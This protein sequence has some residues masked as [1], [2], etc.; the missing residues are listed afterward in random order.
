MYKCYR[1]QRQ[2]GEVEQWYNQEFS[3][4][5]QYMFRLSGEQLNVAAL[6]IV[7]YCLDRLGCVNGIRVC[8]EQVL[9]LCVLR[10][11]VAGEIFPNPYIRQW[12]SM[13]EVQATLLGW[14]KPINDTLHDC[15]SDADTCTVQHNPLQAF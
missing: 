9:T 14:G 7:N 15:R 1:Q 13:Q 3:Q 12:R 6:H 11:L 5:F 10:Q 4:A 2:D 8:E